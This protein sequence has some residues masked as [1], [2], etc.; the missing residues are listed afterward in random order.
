[1]MI[2]EGQIKVLMI[3]HHLEYVGKIHPSVPTERLGLK[4]QLPYIKHFYMVYRIKDIAK[5]LKFV[6]KSKLNFN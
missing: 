5:L 2:Q 1:M 4:V 3:K 6:F